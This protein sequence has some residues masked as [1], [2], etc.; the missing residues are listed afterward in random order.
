M[1]S[2]MDTSVDSDKVS[3]EKVIQEC[4]EAISKSNDAEKAIAGLDI[5]HKLISNILKN[6]GDEK[7][8]ILKKSNKTIQSKLLSLQP[9]ESVTQL[10][11]NLG[12][13]ETDPDVMA[14][15]GNYFV[16]LAHGSA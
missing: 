1:D 10:L 8:R 7:F 11:E 9:Q 16:V 14:F 5:L 13:V 4:L 6:P 12:Y 15:V 2:T 3:R